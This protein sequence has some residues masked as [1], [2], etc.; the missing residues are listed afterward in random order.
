MIRTL[1]S[2]LLVRCPPE[3]LYLYREF[4]GNLRIRDGR[5][6]LASELA[7]T[8]PSLGYLKQWQGRDGMTSECSMSDPFQ[9]LH[10]PSTPC[11]HWPH[12]AEHSE[13][14]VVRQEV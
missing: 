11:V 10:N 13:F 4:G 8:G 5:G 14:C 2:T 1:H 7:D 12:E 6:Q 9:K 3:F